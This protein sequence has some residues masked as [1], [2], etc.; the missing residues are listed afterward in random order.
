MLVLAIRYLNGWA[1]AAADGAKKE[2][3]EWP[4]HP[5]R[6]FMALAAAWFETG[7]DPAEGDALRWLEAE[8]PPDIACT[9]AEIRQST[10][11]PT[12]SYVPVNDSRVGR[13]PP[14][15]NDLGKLKEAGLAALPEFRPRQPRRFPV[16]IP[17]NPVVHLI[18]NNTPNEKHREALQQLATKVI[19]VGHSASLVQLWVTNASPG[20]MWT[21]SEGV[22]PL[23]LRIPSRGYLDALQR[24]HNRA[25]VIAYAD[26]TEQIKT[27]KGKE[28]TKMK[29]AISERFGENPPRSSRPQPGLFIGYKRATAADNTDCSR[30]I[31]DNNLLV[32]TLLGKRPSLPATLKL[33]EALR[34]A[35]M[36]TCARIADET[37]PE[38][39]SGH[40]T[41]GKPT[42]QAHVALLPLPFVGSKHAD[43]RILGLG[44]A[45]PRELDP[46]D[47]AH[48]LGQFLYEENG[49]PRE[50]KLFAG[51]WLESRL[52][53]EVREKP[54]VNLNP[55]TWTQA[56]N[57]WASATPVVLDR[58]FD[59]DDKWEH[60]AE[61]I[62][63][64]CERI[65]LPRPREVVLHPV[66]LIEGVQHAREFPSLV[67]K[68]DGGRRQHTHAVLIFDQPV[69]GPVIVG[70]G[71]FRG[72]GLFRPTNTVQSYD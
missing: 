33:T 3:A 21:A 24:Q 50:L 56:A 38:W 11:R 51:R 65:G 49:L 45:L 43:G 48:W 14:K 18:W 47:S 23:R 22:T 72:Y 28:K 17:H 44:I 63:K 68:Q 59:G 19:C 55:N 13:K 15:K 52:T 37:L 41:D 71:R 2:Q 1:M 61:S 12:I 34:G 70:A 6:V 16:A 7:E 30:S 35:L 58:H 10:D 39:L 54:P 46:E 36:S 67:R 4:P 57:M 29:T 40:T 66:S 64:S 9:D 20:A 5:S 32:F 42:K 8:P 60:A 26:M 27:L 53:L 31:F 62:K 69:Q 25:D